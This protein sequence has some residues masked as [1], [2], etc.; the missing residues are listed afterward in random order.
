MLPDDLIIL[1]IVAAYFGLVLVL[2]FIAGQLMIMLV[3]Y[4][5]DCIERRQSRAS[6]PSKA[7]PY[8]KGHERQRAV[9]TEWR[10]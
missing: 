9:R 2:A 6:Q 1:L 3:E 7:M 4:A 5:A 10:G 8:R